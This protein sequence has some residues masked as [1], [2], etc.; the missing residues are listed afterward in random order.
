MKKILA[1]SGSTRKNSVNKAILESITSVYAEQYDIEIYEQIS[2]FPHFNPDITENLPA[3]ISD[4]IQRIEQ[5]DA[6]IIC[7]PEYVFSIPGT[8]KNALEWTVATVVF[9]D[10]PVGIIVAAAGGEKAFE[11]L[12]LVL[13]T[14]GAKIP[15]QGKLLISGASGK[16]DKITNKFDENTLQKILQVV[17]AIA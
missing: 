9:T 17:V 4:F 3:V 11:S 7:S 14:L 15:E 16:Y 12:E 13:T 1:I 6:V 2:S 5:A 8:L 10:K